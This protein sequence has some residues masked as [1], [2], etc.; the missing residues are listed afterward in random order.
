[1]VCAE[2]KQGEIKSVIQEAGDGGETG[3]PARAEVT[4]TTRGG[5]GT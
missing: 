3:N 4:N 1:M 2:E 5:R